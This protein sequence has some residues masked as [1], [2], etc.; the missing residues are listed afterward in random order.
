MC[1]TWLFLAIFLEVAATILLKLSNGLTGTVPTLG[2][3]V[4]YGLS[5]VPMTIALKEM[6]IGAVY[7][8]WSGWGDRRRRSAGRNRLPRTGQPPQGRS[9]H[10][11]HC[12]RGLLEPV[13]AAVFAQRRPSPTQERS[14]ARCPWKR[15]NHRPPGFPCGGEPSSDS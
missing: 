15:T 14:T 2:M 12:R 7:S 3:F 8:I 6:E 5:F 13:V 4:L 10:A 11:H 9:N 1:W